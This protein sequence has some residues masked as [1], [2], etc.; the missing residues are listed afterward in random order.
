MIKG[1]EAM[2]KKYV[3]ITA[4]RNEQAYIERTIQS[5]ISQTVLPVQWVIVSDGSTDRT[6]EIVNKYIQGYDF[7]ELLRIMGD[8]RRNFV[9]QVRTFKA[10]CKQLKDVDYEFIGN[11][12][13]GI[14]F[15]D[16]CHNN[17]IKRNWVV[18]PIMVYTFITQ[19]GT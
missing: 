7:I 6:D 18:V 19:T 12:D 15:N 13:T 8:S 17:E 2:S 14:Y 11:L 1:H 16:T 5:I 4:A 9:S 10:G 3:L